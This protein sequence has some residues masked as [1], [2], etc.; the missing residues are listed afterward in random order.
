MGRS[1]SLTA[2]S[3]PVGKA[4]LYLLVLLGCLVLILVV[5]GASRQPQAA[6]GAV[7]SGLLAG[8]ALIVWS[9]WYRARHR[10]H[11][12]TLTRQQFQLVQLPDTVL[13]D[14]AMSTLVC[15]RRFS[16]SL[17]GA[18][19]DTIYLDF[20]YG[21]QIRLHKSDYAEYEQLVSFLQHHFPNK[22]FAG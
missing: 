22:Q 21:G 7:V 11:R 16:G 9:L 2:E 18:P 8:L 10:R 3:K 20:R 12:L 15:W 13:A 5:R 1:H 19:I 4:G 14:Y 17:Q 6:T